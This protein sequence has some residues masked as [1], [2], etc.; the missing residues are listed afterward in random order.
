MTSCWSW[1][2]PT[3]V[4]SPLFSSAPLFKGSPFKQSVIS[5]S[6]TSL[7][8]SA[9]LHSQEGGLPLPPE[10]A[11]TKSRST[12]I[13]GGQGLTP[14]LCYIQAE[15][16][17][18]VQE[19]PPQSQ[20]Q[21]EHPIT[22]AQATKHLWPPS[23]CHRETGSAWQQEVPQGS[24]S[25]PSAG[26]RIRLHS[27]SGWTEMGRRAYVNHRAVANSSDILLPAKGTG[28]KPEPVRHGVGLKF[29]CSR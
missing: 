18:A 25:L 24:C 13:R 12:S 29:P 3:L 5:R 17:V 6:C 14:R 20:Y 16:M 26:V 10:A 7:G 1:C 21:S 22:D 8:R 9:G 11:L 15:P 4:T 19:D 2:G 23:E 27:P 28:A